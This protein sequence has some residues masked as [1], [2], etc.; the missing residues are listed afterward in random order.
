M[1]I[2]A[3]TRL[4]FWNDILSRDH[5]KLFPLT[6]K[7]VLGTCGNWADA[8]TLT[9]LLKIEIKNYED[10]HNREMSVNALA[11]LTSTIMYEY[12]RFFPYAVHQLLAGID[13]KG[14]GVVYSYD[15]IGHLEKHICRAAGSSEAVLQPILDNQVGLA[16]MAE[17]PDFVLTVERAVALVHDVFVSAAERDIYTGDGV[18]ISILKDGE[19]METRQVALRKD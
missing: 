12:R 11:Q 19:A 14:R 15:V 18:L 2:G 4:S 1:V 9:S 16:N 6:S 10:T 13:T 17:K 5:V 3:D 8:E 7:A